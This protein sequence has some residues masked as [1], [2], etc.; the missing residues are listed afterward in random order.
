ME[1]PQFTNSG[2][3][4]ITFKIESFCYKLMKTL[5][6][7]IHSDD[8]DEYFEEIDFENP[9]IVKNEYTQLKKRNNNINFNQIIIDEY[10]EV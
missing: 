1:H 7:M 4:N 10:F 3:A 6:C 8:N 5:F 2:P 9:P